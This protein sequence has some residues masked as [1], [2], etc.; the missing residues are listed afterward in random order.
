MEAC[1]T[2]G[3]KA[4][5]NGVPNLSILDGWWN[6][7]YN[8]RNGWAFGEESTEAERDSTDAEAIYRVLEEKIIP[9]YYKSQNHEI[10]HGWVA[11]MKESIKVCGSGFSA[12]RMVHDYINKFYFKI[13]R[14][15]GR[16]RK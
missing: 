8:G 12:R 4:G 14:E 11:M 15:K 10:S 3:M 16:A 6:E 7:G 5:L 1:G 2:S 9:L 13:M